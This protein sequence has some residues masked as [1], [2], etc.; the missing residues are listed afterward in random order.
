[1][2]VNW[3]HVLEVAAAVRA[4]LTRCAELGAAR[5]NRNVDDPSFELASRNVDRI[6]VGHRIV[7]PRLSRRGRR[8]R[9]SGEQSARKGARTKQG[10]VHFLLLLDLAVTAAEEQMGPLLWY[11]HD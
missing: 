10:L 6:L 8:Q 1:M 7:T 5:S 3:V 2:F 4:E 9:G 11:A